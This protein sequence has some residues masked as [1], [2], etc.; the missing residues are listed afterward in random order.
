MVRILVAF[1]LVAA[2]PA[3][4]Q[5]KPNAQTSQPQ[6]PQIE[7]P[8]D[9]RILALVVST[10]LALNQ[11]NSTAN[12]SVFRELGAPGFQLANS[13]AKLS[14]VFTKLRN[15]GFDLSAIVNLTPQLASRPEIK[16]GMLRV[17]GFYPTAPER[18]IFDLMYQP[19]EGQFLLFG[20]AVDTTPSG[21][22][23]G[24]AQ[25]TPN[26]PPTQPEPPEAAQPPKPKPKPQAQTIPDDVR[27]HIHQLEAAAMAPPPEPK[28]TPKAPFNPFSG[29]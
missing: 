21:P 22:T 27:D 25:G 11:A 19:V 28:P 14:S 1:L 9:Q 3:L 29:F 2:S 5:T 13:T 12:Y 7:M 26:A 20:I 17:S 24:H 18:L 15:K 6:P 10:L 16:D 4:A 23:D 8:S